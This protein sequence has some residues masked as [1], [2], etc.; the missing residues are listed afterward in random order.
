MSACRGVRGPADLGFAVEALLSPDRAALLARAA[1]G[2]AT[3][4]AEATNRAIDLIHT[5]LERGS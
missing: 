1:W 5:A 3:A 4:G 2:V